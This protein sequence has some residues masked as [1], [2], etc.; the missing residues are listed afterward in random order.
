MNTSTGYAG[1]CVHLWEGNRLFNRIRAID[2]AYRAVHALG[3][4]GVVIVGLRRLNQQLR[5]GQQG[6]QILVDRAGQLGSASKVIRPSA[7][8]FA[9]STSLFTPSVKAGIASLSCAAPD[10]RVSAPAL[11]CAAPEAASDAPL[12]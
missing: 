5:A 7:S 12:V 4:S 9:P 6:I 1:G 3:Q 2:E 11:S 8:A 10:C